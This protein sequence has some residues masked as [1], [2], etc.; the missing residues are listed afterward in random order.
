[1]WLLKRIQRAL[2]REDRKGRKD[3][4]KTFFAFFAIF[5]VKGL[6]TFVS[7]VQLA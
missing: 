1:M 7:Q 4:Q 5:A 6:L 2:N 3:L